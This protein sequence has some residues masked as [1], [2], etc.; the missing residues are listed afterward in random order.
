M[1]VLQNWVP[2]MKPRR[3]KCNLEPQQKA[4]HLVDTCEQTRALYR[5]HKSKFMLLAYQENGLFIPFGKK[6]VT[7]SLVY[8]TLA[9]V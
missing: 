2:S 4:S 6:N 1:V 5:Y 9:T 3:R 7:V 8:N